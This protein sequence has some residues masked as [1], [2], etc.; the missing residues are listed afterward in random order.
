MADRFRMSDTEGES[1]ANLPWWEL[2]RDNELQKLIRIALRENKNLQ[3]AAATVEEFQARAMIATMDFAPQLN[4][5]ASTPAFGRQ[6]RF[7]TPGFP[8][9][10]NYYIQGNLAWEI[11][12]WGRIRRSNEAA[13]ADLL[14]QEESRRAVV[15]SLVSGVAEAYFDLLQFDMQLDITKRTLRSWEES[16]TIAR[17]RLRQGVTSKLDA[18][19]FEA[20]RANAEARVAQFERQMI[21]KENELSVILGRNPQTISRVVSLTEQVMPPDIPPGLP[22]ELL[23][24][25]PDIVQVEEQLAAATAR[26]GMAKADRFPKLSIT[27]IMGYA[28]PQFSQL[29]KGGGKANG[30]FGEVGPS[31]IGPLLNASVLGFQQDAVEAQARQVLADYEQAIL[32]AFQEVEDA[33]VA[34]HTAESQ[35]KAQEEEVKALRSALRLASLRYKGGITSYVD[36]LI[37]KRNLFD[38]EIALTATHRLHLVSVVQLYKALGG[39]WS[40]TDSPSLAASPSLSKQVSP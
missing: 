6:S 17:A 7:L 9:P 22:S 14:A 32:V 30:Q 20:Q 26:I 36:V 16:V 10:F 33:L 35:R 21:Q 19:Q 38:A 24:R 29:V 4:L 39:G 12:L 40:P 31:L 23:K 34:V 25:R 11:D 15:L 8:N 1:I 13:R 5:A 27:G 18:D 2:L 3:K 28:N 37:A